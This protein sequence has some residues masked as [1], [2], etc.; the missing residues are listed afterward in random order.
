MRKKYENVSQNCKMST[1][2]KHE[3]AIPW[4]MIVKYQNIRDKKNLEKWLHFKKTRIRNKF[5][6]STEDLSDF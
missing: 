3:K 5:L 4:H 2:T 6:L 1:N